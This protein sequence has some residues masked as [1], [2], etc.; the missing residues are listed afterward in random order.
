MGEAMA[1]SRVLDWTLILVRILGPL[2]DLAIGP[3]EIEAVLLGEVLLLVYFFHIWFC[4]VSEVLLDRY[5][6]LGVHHQFFPR[7][8]SFTRGY[9]FI[10]FSAW[11]L[12]SG[13]LL[14]S[15]LGM[16]LTADVPLSDGKRFRMAEFVP[17]LNIGVPDRLIQGRLSVG[18]ILELFVRSSLD[19]TSGRRGNRNE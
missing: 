15:L 11:E 2:L 16:G 8:R 13:K 12:N 6:G 14:E 3:L 10:E 5:L 1:R 19:L 4:L 9:G 17:D 7:V 18:L